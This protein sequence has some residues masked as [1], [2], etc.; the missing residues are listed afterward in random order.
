MFES[1]RGVA[2]PHFEET[3]CAEPR[4]ILHTASI[5]R[6][7]LREVGTGCSTCPG[8]LTEGD[9]MRAGVGIKYSVF[10]FLELIARLNS[11]QRRT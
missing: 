2:A 10:A 9:S 7:R 3:V 8:A 1:N 11:L 6:A 4:N 5:Q